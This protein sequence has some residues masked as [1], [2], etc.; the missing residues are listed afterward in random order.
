MS[1][2][3][4]LHFSTEALPS[5][6]DNPTMKLLFDCP[7]CGDDC[8]IDR[9]GLGRGVP[10]IRCGH[11]FSVTMSKGF[12]LRQ[13]VQRTNMRCPHCKQVKVVALSVPARG[14]YCTACSQLFDVATHAQT[15]EAKDA[16]TVLASAA[17]ATKPTTPRQQPMRAAYRPSR[18]HGPWPLWLRTSILILA[19][20][21][22]LT[23]LLYAM[24][25]TFGPATLEQ[26]ATQFTHACLVGEFET[27]QGRFV[28]DDQRQHA[29]FEQWQLR[30]FVSIQSKFRPAD[31][32]VTVEVQSTSNPGE[33]QAFVVT[34]K[35]PFL[36]ERT[37]SQCWRQHEGIWQFDAVETVRREDGL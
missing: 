33:V 12:L 25:R 18:P 24:P 26:I 32:R 21:G 1:G 6:G 17:P 23:A 30:H 2:A 19:A 37:A 27:A 13:R 29:A 5:A 8:W 31:D 20:V 16:T 4:P 3:R 7:K 14:A 28:A 35:S 36:G 34:L 9:D 15:K 11:R 10:C 22:S